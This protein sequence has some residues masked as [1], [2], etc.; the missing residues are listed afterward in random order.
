LLDSLQTQQAI[1]HIDVEVFVADNDPT[2]REAV[3]LCGEIEK[4]FRWPLFCEVVDQPGIS[5]ARNAILDQAREM[6]SDFVAMLDDDETA[7]PRWLGE[8][9]RVQRNTDASVVSGPVRRQLQGATAAI[10][11]SGIFPTN[12]SEEGPVPQLDASGNILIS[13]DWLRR[14]GWPRFDLSFGLTGG[15]DK[16]YFTRIRKRGA[17]FAWAPSAEAVEH[18]PVERATMQAIV[19]RAFRIGNGDMRILRAHGSYG[20]MAAS[21]AKGVAIFVTAPLCSPLLLWPSW[22]IWL[23]AKW[24]R[25]AGKFAAILGHHYRA[26]AD[27]KKISLQSNS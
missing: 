15:E 22:R 20:D 1:D 16:E 11:N 25:S 19:S 9:L 2:D 12:R 17:S 8:L 4:S 24:S 7:E 6:N 26:Y 10:R 3:E 13:C 21:L 27:V 14:M 23:L 5:A 18:V